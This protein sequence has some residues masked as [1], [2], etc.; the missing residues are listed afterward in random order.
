MANAHANAAAVAKAVD[1]AATMA[2]RDL[3]PFFALCLAAA[4]PSGPPSGSPSGSPSGLP[5]GLVPGAGG[6]FA[7]LR[8]GVFVPL[9][10][11]DEAK[12]QVV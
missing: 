3:V 4:S 2:R 1:A 12:F 6:A 5:L 7:A 9:G 8:A 10:V 11:C